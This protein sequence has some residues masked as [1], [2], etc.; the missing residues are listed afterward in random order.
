MIKWLDAITITMQTYDE[1]N[2]NKHKIQNKNKL[3]Q[4]KDTKTKDIH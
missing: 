1:I 2:N 4:T 3:I